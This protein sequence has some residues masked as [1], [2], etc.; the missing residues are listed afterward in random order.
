M[1]IDV[2][3]FLFSTA[4]ATHDPNLSSWIELLDSLVDDFANFL[5]FLSSHFVQDVF[6]AVNANELVSVK[7]VPAFANG[8]P[9]VTNISEAFLKQVEGLKE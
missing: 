7:K 6:I 3:T 1:N 9:Y 8:G 2:S 5:N 4:V